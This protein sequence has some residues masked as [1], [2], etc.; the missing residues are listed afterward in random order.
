MPKGILISICCRFF[1]CSMNTLA[2]MFE[3]ERPVVH[4][5]ISKMIIN[6]ELQVMKN[7]GVSR[8]LR[9]NVWNQQF[10]GTT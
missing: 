1:M 7:C 5:I 2:E 8:C 4:S 6:S 10:V 3:L 9:C